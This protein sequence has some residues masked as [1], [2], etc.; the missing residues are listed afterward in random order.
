VRSFAAAGFVVVA[1][2]RLS[3]AC[4][5]ACACTAPTSNDAGTWRGQVTDPEGASHEV[6]ATLDIR[7]DRV[8]GTIAVPPESA[9]A[10]TN[11]RRR[12]DDLTFE[13]GLVGPPEEHAHI[14][15]EAT[16][17]GDELRGT[18]TMPDGAR[19]PFTLA[20]VR[21]GA[22]HAPAR[23]AE[24]ADTSPP[25]P[26]GK[27]PEPGEPQAAIIAAFDHY[28]L[29]GGMSASHGNKDTDDFLLALIRNPA[30][31]KKVNDIAV[32]C[33][34]ARYQPVLDRY[35]AGEDVPLAEVRQVWR[36]TS[37][38]NCGFSAFYEQLFPLVRRINATLPREHRLRVL[39]CDPPIDWSVVH[40]REDLQGFE[41]RDRSIAAVIEREV[42]A[43]GRKALL[44]FGVNHVRHGVNAAARY[45]VKHRGVAFVIADHHGFGGPT[46]LGAHNDALEARMAAWPVPSLVTLAG[47]W[48][49]ALPC[50]YFDASFAKDGCR[51]YPGVDGYLYVGRRDVLLREP[52]SAAA[53]LD[54]AY[55]RELR[56][57]ATALGLP[58][59]TDPDEAFRSELE[60]SAFIED[61]AGGDPPRAGGAA[62]PAPASAR[63]SRPAPAPR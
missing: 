62:P 23:P 1:M 38:P 37:Q 24:S 13:L 47:T 16:L 27:D 42:L 14:A 29:V 12:G 57:R 32:E 51:G 39:A 15:F 36:D 10:I 55:V 44:L 25:R 4:V 41:D 5:V 58:N 33:G 19:L 52:A 54:T 63:R 8:T 11:G 45:E 35:I 26:D 50:A 61:R 43:K 2:R 56:R 49:G 9:Q 53:V 21:D 6:T 17:S 40:R 28:D 48:L 60:S 3:L 46:P 20:R 18:A 59:S 34:N 30:L 22:P 31:P 7:G